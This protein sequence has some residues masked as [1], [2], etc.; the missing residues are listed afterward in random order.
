[1]VRIPRE[2]PHRDEAARA[3]VRTHPAAARGV[4]R[5]HADRAADEPCVERPAA[6]PGL[7]R[8]DPHHCLEPDDD[9]HH[10]RRARRPAAAARAHRTR[11]AAAAQRAGHSVLAAHPPGG[12]GGAGR[13][14]AA[15]HG[16]GGSGQ[17]CASGEGL[18]RRGRHRRAAEGGGRRHPPC[19]DGVR[20]HSQQVPSR[21]RPAAQ[22][23]AHRSAGH[24]WP[25]RAR[26]ADDP[27]RDARVHAVHRAAHLPAAQPRHDSG[28]RSTRRRSTVAGERSALHGAS[29]GRPGGAGGA[30][31][32]Q[33]GRCRAIRSRRVRLRPRFDRAR[34]LPPRD[35]GRCVG[36][37]RRRDRKWQVHGRP[38]PGALLRHT[39]RGDH[40]R[41]RRRPRPHARRP[42]PRGC[43]RVRGHVPVPRH[44]GCQ[45]RVL[46]PRCVCRR[47]RSCGATVGRT[48]LHSRTPRWLRHVA[49]RARL[50]AQRRAAP[51]HCTR[52]RHPRRPS[53]AGARRCHQRGR[54]VEGA[55]DPGGNGH[56]DAGPHHHR[57]R[58]P[59]RHHRPRRHGGAARRGAGRRHRHP[60]PSLLATSEQYRSV[61]AALSE[62]DAELAAE[63]AE[64]A[65]AADGTA[66]TAEVR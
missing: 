19:L 32:G 65:A 23:G 16:G 51:A 8:D 22:P 21:S 28:V 37:H 54:P 30:A 29:R 66:A 46:A 12:V 35:P 6:D 38:P 4:P 7:R 52:A 20:P 5:P 45:R 64:M 42:A 58:A 26:R 48:R 18:R 41:R 25:P 40:H 11:T 31:V 61:L 49:G 39:S 34:R 59:A 44:G 47:H 2:P 62:R 1:M 10:R 14:G 27:R 33:S 55:R 15:G 50:L 36:G 3:A 17:R 57:D 60:R 13:A 53:R 24:R 9:R 63:A 56:G 43:H